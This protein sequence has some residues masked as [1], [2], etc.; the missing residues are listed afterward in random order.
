MTPHTLWFIH[1][2][3]LCL[4]KF[5]PVI[6]RDTTAKCET[7]PDTASSVGVKFRQASKADKNDIL[8]M[9]KNTSN[10]LDYLPDYFDYYITY[11]RRLCIVG[12]TEGEIVSKTKFRISRFVFGEHLCNY[13]NFQ[14]NQE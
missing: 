4:Y 1:T 14:R 13:T 11:P 12:E 5:L 9:R 6:L 7:L 2:V 3:F 8:S 10:G